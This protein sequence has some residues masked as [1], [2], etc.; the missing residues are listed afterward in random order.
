MAKRNQKP[1]QHAKFFRLIRILGDPQV[2]QC[3]SQQVKWLDVP[4]QD[5]WDARAVTPNIQVSQGMTTATWNVNFDFQNT[6]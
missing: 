3:H 1:T 2:Y 4:L 6:K 5:A